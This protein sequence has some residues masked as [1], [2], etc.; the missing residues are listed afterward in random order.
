MAQPAYAPQTIPADE[1]SDAELVALAQVGDR[2]AFAQLVERHKRLVYGLAYRLL[3]DPA[4]AEDA[5]QETF[6][7]AYTRL[8]TYAPEHRFAA[9]LGAICSHWC[10]DCLRARRRRVPT[11]ALGKVAEG[12]RFISPADGP[13]DHA[14]RGAGQDEVRQLLA[15][16]PTQYREILVLRYFH[17]LSYSEIAAELGE[18]IST[19]RMRLYRARL[20]FHALAPTRQ[21][22]P[23]RAHAALLAASR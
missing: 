20:M 9:W 23:A 22:L 14:L 5:A 12:G 13:E 6:V 16:L 8:N 19:V 2:A 10:I 7:R 4:D 21:D 18:P 11:V 3:G 15:M 17:D 1:R